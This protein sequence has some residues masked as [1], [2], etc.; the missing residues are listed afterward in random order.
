[1]KEVTYERD[2]LEQKMIENHEKYVAIADEKK[3][4]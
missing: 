4:L 2:R 1:M 3:D